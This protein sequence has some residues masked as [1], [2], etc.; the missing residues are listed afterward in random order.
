MKDVLYMIFGPLAV[1][2]FYAV[3]IYGLVKLVKFAWG[4]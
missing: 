4:A 2:S 3:I 1:F